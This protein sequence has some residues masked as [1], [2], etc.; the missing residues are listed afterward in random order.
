MVR[1]TKNSLQSSLTILPR[2]EHR[3]ILEFSEPERALYDYLERV[4]Y[5]QVSQWRK[6][7]HPDHMRAAASLLYLRLKQGQSSFV[8][9]R[10][11]LL[12]RN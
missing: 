7:E 10:R 6:Q 4:L 1:R 12:K 9:V 5:Q 2:R 8:S 11:Y 3:V